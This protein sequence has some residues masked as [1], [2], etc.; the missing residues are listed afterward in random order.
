MLYWLITTQYILT[1]AAEGEQPL[2]K[3]VLTEETEEERREVDLVGHSRNS[4]YASKQSEVSG[5]SS[6][7]PGGGHSRQS[8]SSSITHHRY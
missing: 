4:S 2:K 1:F 6:S 3:E 5:Y 8:S 7:I